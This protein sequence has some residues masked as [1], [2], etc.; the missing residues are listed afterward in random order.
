MKPFFDWL[1][2]VGASGKPIGY[3]IGFVLAALVL[4]GIVFLALRIVE[5]LTGTGGGDSARRRPAGILAQLRDAAGWREAAARF[6]AAGD[7]A[8]AVAA[9]F[10]AAL[11]TFDEEGLIAFDSA[12]T[13]GEYRRLVRR[14][15]AGEGD[16]FDALA[17]AFVRAAFSAEAVSAADYARA[18]DAYARLRP[19]AA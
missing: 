11:A 6:A 13:P 1:H 16:A 17:D 12:R 3:A 18:E 14:T 5:A 10:S 9:L 7:Y 19:L 8:R 15:A 2:G 4:A